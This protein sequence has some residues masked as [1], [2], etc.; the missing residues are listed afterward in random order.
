MVQHLEEVMTCIM[1][2]NAASNT[3]SYTNFGYTYQPPSG[4]SNRKTI[5]A[6]TEYFPPAEVEVFDL[7]GEN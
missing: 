7:S 3:D 5:L 2:N 4:V 6:G 1:S